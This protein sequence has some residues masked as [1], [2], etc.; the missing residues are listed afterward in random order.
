MIHR[1]ECNQCHGV[2]QDVQADG[3]IYFHACPE[4]RLDKK[5]RPVP[6]VGGRDENIATNHA[7]SV[8]GIRLEGAGV[9]CLSDKKLKEPKWITDLK[10]KLPAEDDE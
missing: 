2:Y 9:T 4:P 8:T 10:S 7:G 6:R 1:F 5:G 3:A